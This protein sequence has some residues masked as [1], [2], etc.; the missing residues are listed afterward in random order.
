[1]ASYISM[2][3]KMT[4]RGERTTFSETGEQDQR[5]RAKRHVKYAASVAVVLA[6][7][8][9]YWSILSP[10]GGEPSVTTT[11][12]TNL[13]PTAREVHRTGDGVAV[14]PMEHAQNPVVATIG[15]ESARDLYQFFMSERESQDAGRVYQAYRAW[16][17]CNALMADANGLRAAF[18]GGVPAGLSGP[19]TPERAAAN[20]ELLQRCRG[21]ERVGA[22]GLEELGSTT[23]V[24]AQQLGSLEAKFDS[25]DS[26]VAP[27]H[28]SLV[29]LLQ[30]HTPSAFE[31]AAP[32]L[33]HSFAEIK[34]V[35]TD[36]AQYLQIETAVTL[37]GCDLGKDCSASA[38]P[39]LLHCV[40]YN[41]C[42]P[43][44]YAGWQD[45]LSENEIKQILALKDDIIR[46]V[47]VGELH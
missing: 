9:G 35:S 1:M 18:A 22:R 33:V 11:P 29:G 27:D 28:A 8:L 31:R 44:L 23:L 4:T 12:N 32:A 47:K 42:L 38:Y 43:S 7:V 6:L 19:L 24:K 16:L 14:H 20:T 37:A 36:S 45:G 41:Q 25:D 46:R 2:E 10:V 13:R 26:N 39:A 21:F 40:Y 17:E 3:K 34:G 15:Y 5:N 30:T